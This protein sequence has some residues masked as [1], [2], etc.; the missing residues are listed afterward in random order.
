MT[1]RSDADTTFD[2]RRPPSKIHEFRSSYS[3]PHLLLLWEQ[4]AL[5]RRVFV[6]ALLAGTVVAFLIPNLYSSK[7]RIMPPDEQ[8]GAAMLA[9][10]LGKGDSPGLGTLA[11]IGLGQKTNGALYAYLLHSRTV[12]D[13]IVER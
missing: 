2:P 11:Q 6:Y 1:I 4:R 5:V 3:S 9:S 10:L 13:R 7:A 12:Q 8:G